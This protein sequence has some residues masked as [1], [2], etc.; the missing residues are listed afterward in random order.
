MLS[1]EVLLSHQTCKLKRPNKALV[2]LHIKSLWYILILYLDNQIIDVNNIPINHFPENVNLINEST[3]LALGNAGVNDSSINISNNTNIIYCKGCRKNCHPDLFYDS[4]RNKSFK[5]CNDCRR[6]VFNRRHPESVH[7]Q[8]T[9]RPQPS[10]A[11]E[12]KRPFVF[13]Y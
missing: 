9:T 7:D 13:C 8:L 3:N 6:R 2:C 5:Q 1:K 4:T 12:C 11:C 10:T